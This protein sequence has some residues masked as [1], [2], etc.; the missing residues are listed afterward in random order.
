MGLVQEFKDFTMRGNV[1]D[2]AVGVIIGGAF[3]KVVDSMVSDVIMPPIGKI[4]SGVSFKDIKYV[5]QEAVKE[6]D[7]VIKPEIAINLG[8]F[9]LMLINFIIVAFVLF[10]LIKAYNTAK[11][12]EAEA[13]A[14]PPAPTTSEVLLT[15]IRDS[16]RSR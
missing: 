3:G 1:L 13:P 5:L 4:L 16:L 7:K 9:V 8:N 6:G 2:L 10:M 14:A 11:K 15:E 12:K